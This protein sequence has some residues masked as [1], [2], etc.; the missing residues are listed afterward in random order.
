VKASHGPLV[1]GDTKEAGFLAIRVNPSMNADKDGHMRNVYG[2][3]DEVGCWSKPSHWMDYYGPI[4]DEV[5]G[6][7][8][9][10][11][12]NNFRYPTAWHVR[13]YGLFAPNRWIFK[14]E[15]HLAKDE[16][17]ALRWRVIIHAGDTDSADI[18]NRFLDFADG[19]R[20]TWL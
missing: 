1:F 15:H 14:P 16:S 12:P 6:F 13:G 10:D 8:V 11:H 2:A 9:F 4:D 3:A 19:P 17:M 20:A 5:A 7:A 18:R